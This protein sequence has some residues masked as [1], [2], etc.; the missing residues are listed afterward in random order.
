MKIV[1][2]ILLGI[3][4][5][6][7]LLL[8]IGL[9]I[10]RDYTVSREITIN[11]PVETVFNYVVLLKN[12]DHYS[13]WAIMDPNMKKEYKGTDGTV[14]FV[15]GWDSQNKDL[16]KGEQEITKIE[17]DK[18]IDYELRFYRPFEAVEQA[19]MTTEPIGQ[20]STHVVW[21]FDGHL[22]YPVN[23]ML[24]F[25]NFD[26]ILGADLQGGLKRLK[27]QLESSEN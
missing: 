2:R 19:Y 6:I 20:D 5:V 16:G 1:K 26:K 15:S 22:N 3:A 12:Q 17:P 23:L 25:V 14:G 21:G 9:F 4:G 18:R 13:K 11:E 7:V 27:H 8:V 24:L 10:K